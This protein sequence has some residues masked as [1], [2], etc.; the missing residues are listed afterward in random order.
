MRTHNRAEDYV[1]VENPL[2]GRRHIKVFKKTHCCF[3]LLFLNGC[4]ND[5]WHF[6]FA[7]SYPAPISEIAL[8][9]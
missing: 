8:D 2:W 5:I 4:I 1:K 3:Y 7:F 6:T 9:T